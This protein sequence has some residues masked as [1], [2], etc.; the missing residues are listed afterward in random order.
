V[1]KKKPKKRASGKRN[2]RSNKGWGRGEYY[3]IGELFMAGIGALL[4]VLA[5]GILITSLLGD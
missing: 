4:I 1:A 3:S 2:A 5:I